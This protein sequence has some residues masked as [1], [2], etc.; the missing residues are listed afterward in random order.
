MTVT[1]MAAALRLS[2]ALLTPLA[3][4]AAV[5]QNMALV[6]RGVVVGGDLDLEAMRAGAEVGGVD[7]E[8]SLTALHGE[9]E[10]GDLGVGKFF[11]SHANATGLGRV[12]TTVEDNFD[13]LARGPMKSEDQVGK[14]MI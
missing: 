8:A 4:L 9:E 12:G 10:F 1:V 2:L 7:E 6:G 13:R 3:P 11:E 5:P 14:F